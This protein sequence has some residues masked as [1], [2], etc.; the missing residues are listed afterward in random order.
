MIVGENNFKIDNSNYTAP[1]Y[2]YAGLKYVKAKD[3]FDRAVMPPNGP[4]PVV[5]V[6]AFWRKDWENGI[7]FIGSENSE[8]PTVTLSVKI[9][10]GHLL[11]A[12]DLSKAI[13]FSY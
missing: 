13:S 5:K 1:D 6:P 12:N 7:K 4:N 9:P 11:N 8:L 3:N 10:G 2:G